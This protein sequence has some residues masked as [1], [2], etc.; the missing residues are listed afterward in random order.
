MIEEEEEYFEK[1]VARPI[2]DWGYDQWRKV[3]N[4]A[5]WIREESRYR[6]NRSPSE[7]FLRKYMH[8]ISNQSLYGNTLYGYI[9]KDSLS[10]EFIKEF[11]HKLHNNRFPYVVFTKDQ[12]KHER[13]T[14][15]DKKLIKGLKENPYKYLKSRATIATV[16]R[17]IIRGN[18]IEVDR[19]ITAPKSKL[20]INDI[21]RF[22][23]KYYKD[24]DVDIEDRLLE[25]LE[26]DPDAFKNFLKK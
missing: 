18:F 21:K 26:K 10:K 9:R 14:T 6:I 12:L 7:E 5:V 20:F 3:L 16:A 19:S 17:E 25:I 1:L 13:F 15:K 24:I 23:S 11:Y 2:K 4:D 8:S 22:Y